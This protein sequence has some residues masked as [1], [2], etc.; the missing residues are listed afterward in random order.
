M[1]YWRA[2]VERPDG[3]GGWTTVA[4][5]GTPDTPGNGTARHLHGDTPLEAAQ[6]LLRHVWPINLADFNKRDDIGMWRDEREAKTNIADHRITI[7]ICE[8]NR[9]SHHGDPPEPLS[10]TVAELYLAEVRTE[11]AE[12]AAKQARLAELTEQVR[13]ARGDVQ[14]GR[15]RVTHAKEDA[16]RAGVAEAEVRKAGRA[17]RRP[18][19]PTTT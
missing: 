4:V 14:H 6:I 7:D 5:F 12:L 18:A 19:K 11:V 8:A 16:T 13:R 1:T 9:W 17:P 2:T 3:A 10:V 15:W